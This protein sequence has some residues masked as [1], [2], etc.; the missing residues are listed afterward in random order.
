MAPVLARLQAGETVAAEELE[1]LFVLREDGFGTATLGLVWD[2][3]SLAEVVGHL[4]VDERHRQPYGIVHGG[5]WCAVVESLASVAAALQV[6]AS[7]RFVVGVSNS[8]DFLRSHREG[9]VDAVATPVHVG[10]TQQ[11]WQVVLSRADDGVPIA[12]GQVRLA[13]IDPTQVAG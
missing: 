9:R 1:G 3:I 8:T 4:E 5:V 10:R 12:R 7:G 11:L 2:R 6:A 13:N